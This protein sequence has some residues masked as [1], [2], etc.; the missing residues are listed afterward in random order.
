MKAENAAKSDER[1]EKVKM[2][3]AQKPKDSNES[4]TTGGDTTN[5]GVTE[6]FVNFIG[7]KTVIPNPIDVMPAKNKI[8]PLYEICSLHLDINRDT[9]TAFLLY[10]MKAYYHKFQSTGLSER[11]LSVS[12]VDKGE[13]VTIYVK[14]GGY[15]Y[16]STNCPIP[17][18]CVKSVKN[19]SEE[20]KEDV[21]NTRKK[22]TKWRSKAFSKKKK[23]TKTGNI[24][25]WQGFDSKSLV[26]LG[27]RIAEQKSGYE[28]DR[29]TISVNISGKEIGIKLFLDL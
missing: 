18:K 23:Q 27:K 22:R 3:S 11:W 14:T 26:A 7:G 1:V 16:C 19:S 25:S 5:A 28:F 21:P 8:L 29:S 13:E 20:K 17:D 10:L 2:E 15:F 12:Q 9:T 4:D 6:H 24:I